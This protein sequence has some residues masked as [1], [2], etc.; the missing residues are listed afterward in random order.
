MVQIHQHAWGIRF[1]SRSRLLI[2][3]P[4]TG[5]GVPGPEGL[6][7]L[8]D[9][10][11]RRRI[12]CLGF[13]TFVQS[14]DP[15]G[16]TTPHRN[17]KLQRQVRGSTD[18]WFDAIDSYNPATD[19]EVDIGEDRIHCKNLPGFIGLADWQMVFKC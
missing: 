3:P 1:L 5:P 17:V 19:K 15:I 13:F 18:D 9:E 7:K 12:F 14:L 8:I 4:V 10:R 6:C 16:T 2:D 11:S